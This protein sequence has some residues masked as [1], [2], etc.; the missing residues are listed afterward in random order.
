MA[1][2]HF[3]LIEQTMNPGL[4]ANCLRHLEQRMAKGN[5]NALLNGIVDAVL[6]EQIE[7]KKIA[8]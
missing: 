8:V 6:N 7:A 1:A 4:Q 5:I 3:S 2:I